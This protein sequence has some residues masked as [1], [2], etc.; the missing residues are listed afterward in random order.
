[1]K[2][3]RAADKASSA[4]RS[5]SPCG[6]QGDELAVAVP[7]EHVRLQAERLQQ[8]I[9]DRLRPRQRR[10]C[11]IGEVSACCAAVLGARRRRRA[12]GKIISPR[13]GRRNRF[14][15]DARARVG[16]RRSS[17]RR[18]EVQP[19]SRPCRCTATL[20]QEQH[21]IWPAGVAPLAWL[22]GG[23][24]GWTV[25]AAGE[26]RPRSSSRCA[27]MRGARLGPPVRQRCRESR[28][29]SAGR[30]SSWAAMPRTSATSDSRS[31]RPR[32]T[33]SARPGVGGAPATN[34]VF[35]AVLLEH[36]GG[37]SFRRSRR[38]SAH[39]RA[40][41]V[42]SQGQRLVQHVQ[43]RV[44]RRGTAGLGVFTPRCGGST[45]WCSA[46]AA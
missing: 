28:N 24:L 22:A 26:P 46:S 27:T 11:D 3:P 12:R 5:R 29:A 21:A 41:P 45:R 32:A 18:P 33:S 13:S 37:S 4:R 40:S 17:R 8:A 15:K 1:M 9:Q 10:L 44:V 2:R 38:R 19:T 36:G 6:V 42:V 30:A 31:A 39:A 20:A 14:A 16:P 34:P 25:D 23:R 43:R 35:A 7:G